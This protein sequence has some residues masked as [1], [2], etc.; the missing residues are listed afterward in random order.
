MKGFFLRIRRARE[1]TQELVGV[2]VFLLP[3]DVQR[4][5]SISTVTCKTTKI[6]QHQL[7]N[8]KMI[9]WAL[10]EHKEGSI[11]KTYNNGW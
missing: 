10:Q 2:V 1:V 9:H 6:Q 3:L 8:I 7:T 11:K 4:C 5:S